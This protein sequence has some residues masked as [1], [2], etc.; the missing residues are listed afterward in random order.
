[1]AVGPTG[2]PLFAIDIAVE[3]RNSDHKVI[4]CRITT[5]ACLQDTTSMTTTIS[6]TATTTTKIMTT[7]NGFRATTITT[8]MITTNA[9]SAAAGSN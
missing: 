9:T 8:I 6:F 3:I 2:I 7:T 1:M 5:N 4:R